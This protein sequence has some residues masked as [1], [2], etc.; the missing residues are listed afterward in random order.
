MRTS[1]MILPVEDFEP[2]H[3]Q[4]RTTFHERNDRFNSEET[5]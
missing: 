2:Q 1:K 4:D 5:F 3:V